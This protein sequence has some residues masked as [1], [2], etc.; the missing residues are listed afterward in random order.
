MS[1]GHSRSSDCSSAT[2]AVPH[3]DY[4]YAHAETLATTGYFSCEPPPS[5]RLDD[6]LAQLEDAPLDDFLH[7]HLLR[8]LSKKRPEELRDLAATCYDAEADV[9]TRPALA[10]LLLECALL[11]PAWRQMYDA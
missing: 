3:V 7:Q 4:A 9:F 6:A 10:G 1:S 5:L 11:L 2:P 8:A